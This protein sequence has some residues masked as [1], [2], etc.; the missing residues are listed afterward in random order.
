MLLLLRKLCCVE[1]LMEE[2][3]V[4]LLST[5]VKSLLL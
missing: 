1:G 3:D 2:I 4:Y 5:L